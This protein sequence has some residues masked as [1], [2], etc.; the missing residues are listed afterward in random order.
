MNKEQALRTF[1]KN[2]IEF[3]T[4]GEFDKKEFRNRVRKFFGETHGKRF[5][6]PNVFDICQ[7]L[8]KFQIKSAISSEIVKE[9]VD[10][11]PIYK[12]IGDAKRGELKS[13]I[14]NNY[15][16][17]LTEIELKRIDKM[18]KFDALK[19]IAVLNIEDKALEDS[20]ALTEEN[21]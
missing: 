12:D 11:F 1:T 7:D 8:V 2:N 14:G 16:S 6:I 21:K 9:Q 15:S 17:A 3:L 4:S 5:G 10:I 20:I 13:I 19:S 18:D